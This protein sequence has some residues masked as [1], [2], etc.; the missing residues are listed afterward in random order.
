MQCNL[1]NSDYLWVLSKWS[2][3]RD[4]LIREVMKLVYSSPIKMEVVLLERSWIMDT[5][6]KPVYIVTTYRS[7]LN[8][9]MVL[10]MACLHS[11][12]SHYIILFHT[13]RHT[14][15]RNVTKCLQQRR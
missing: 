13:K 9:E 10:E 7:N 14:V 5:V 3:Q 11:I 2:E 1:S 15:F 12:E 4:G 8:R 6:S